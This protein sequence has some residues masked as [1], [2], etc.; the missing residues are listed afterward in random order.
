MHVV[1]TNIYCQR[2]IES[3]LTQNPLIYAKLNMND[4]CAFRFVLA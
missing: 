2:R 3:E 4:V 1:E